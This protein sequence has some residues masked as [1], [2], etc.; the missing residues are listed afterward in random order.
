MTT[1]ARY[2]RAAS[3]GDVTRYVR[4]ATVGDMFGLKSLSAVAEKLTGLDF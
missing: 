4:A 2:V 3:A 1:V